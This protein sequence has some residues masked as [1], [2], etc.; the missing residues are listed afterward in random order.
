MVDNLLPEHVELPHVLDLAVYLIHLT[1]WMVWGGHT[2][3]FSLE[4]SFMAKSYGWGGGGPCDYSI[5]PSPI[6]LWI[7][8]FFVFGIGIGSRGTGFGTRARQFYF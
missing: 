6:G 4:H 5:T 8:Y 3:T 2:E 7:F 1:T